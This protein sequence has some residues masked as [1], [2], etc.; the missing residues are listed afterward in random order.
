MRW[1]FVLLTLGCGRIGF[2]PEGTTGTSTTCPPGMTCRY[3]CETPDDCNHIDCTQAVSCELDCNGPGTCDGTMV[4]CNANCTWLCHG[5][6]SC[7]NNDVICATGQCHIVCC[8]GSSPCGNQN[9]GAVS[10]GSA[11]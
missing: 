10:S 6:S 5:A 11:C 1:A 8:P 3:D 2:D 4:A 9:G 7:N